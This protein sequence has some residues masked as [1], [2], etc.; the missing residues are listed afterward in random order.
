M[1]ERQQPWYRELTRYHWFVLLVAALGWMFDC[2]DQQ[3]FILA[4]PAAMKELVVPQETPELT[5]LEI[6]K[7][8]NYA[9]SIFLMGWA[10]G[11]LFFGVLGDRIGRAKTMLITILMYSLFTGLSALSRGVWDF[12]F[13][14]FLTGLGVGG[15]FAVGVALVA[16]V[17]PDKARPYA[18]ATL[19]AL[20]AIG[21][22]TAAMI[23]LGLGVAEEEG[24]VTSPWRVM[25][26]IGAVPALLA[27]VI[28]MW[29]KEPEKWQKVS[30]DGAV[31]K[32]LGSYTLLFQHPRWRKHALLGLVLASSGVIGL[33]AV[34][35]FTPD[36]IREVQRQ[37][38]ATGVFDER[39][40]QAQSA[41]DTVLVSQLEQIKQ[42]ELS[43]MSERQDLPADL[44]EIKAGIE[45]AISGRLSRWASLTSILI[46]VGAAC[47]M[48]GFGIVSQRIGRRPTFAIALVAAFFS[49]VSVFWFLKDISQMWMVPVMGFCQLSLF[50]GYAMYF[51]ELFPTH[52][53]S[54][55]TSFCYN[56]GRFVAAS[57]PLVQAQLIAFFAGLYGSS[58]ADSTRYAGIT[59][60]SIFVLGLIVLPFL[61]ET[62][63]QPLP[64]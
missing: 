6:K 27:V 22:I 3:L 29:L 54:T 24:L 37:G 46:N 51:P 35:F 56:V 5:A 11:G 2:L 18:L 59:M 26:V 39:L 30:H 57:G 4:R 49:T 32:Q 63:N 16:E 45:P 17:M 60:C 58:G 21:N 62:R 1:I 55:G 33:W 8:G 34:G 15:E 38:V 9:T 53:R 13:Y 36:L 42:Y 44:A 52:L 23:N 50:A 20:S 47:G 41:G 28:R 10:T 19:Q 31:T 43:P 64:E 7:W 12:A 40:T 61:P 14:R 25:F 48:F